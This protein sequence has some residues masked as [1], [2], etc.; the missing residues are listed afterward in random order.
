MQTQLK[1]APKFPEL[2]D[3]DSE[4]SGDNDEEPEPVKLTDLIKKALKLPGFRC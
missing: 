4:D 2:V 1:I 3:T